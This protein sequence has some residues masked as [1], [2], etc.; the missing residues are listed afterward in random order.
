M[1]YLL[2]GFSKPGFKGPLSGLRGTTQNTHIFRVGGGRGVD[3][4]GDLFPL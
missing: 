2:S 4:L 3:V 1:K